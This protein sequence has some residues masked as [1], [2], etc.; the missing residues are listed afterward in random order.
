MIPEAMEAL[1]N[2]D[3]IVGYK[4][5]IALI[6][7]MFPSKM[8][9]SKGMRQ[10]TER[11]KIAIEYALAGKKVALISSGDSGIYGMAGLALELCKE[12]GIRVKL[13]RGDNSEIANETSERSLVLRV[14]PGVSALNAAASILG[15]PIM[16]DFATIS[17]S[18]HLTPWELIE[19]RIR[20]A[21][22]GDFVIILYNP[23]SLTRPHLLEKAL[24][25]IKTY[26]SLHT[27]VGIVWKAMREGQKSLICSL[28]SIPVDE[29]DMHSTVI[30]GNSQT[31][32]W[33]DLMITPRGYPLSNL[34]SNRKGG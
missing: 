12:E 25:I 29:V 20:L 26:R 8:L 21:A 1:H 9:I 4:T 24:S 6:R 18:D 31:Y 27:P 28:D 2:A 13:P 23:R 15:A 16:H 17:L 22:E 10:E 11:C 19:R 5:Y 33:N 32:V 34:E 30:I 3:V 14:I 7:D